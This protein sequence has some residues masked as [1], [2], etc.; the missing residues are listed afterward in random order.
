MNKQE[1]IKQFLNLLREDKDLQR[2]WEDNI[3]MVFK[4]I[5][6]YEF[7]KGTSIHDIANRSASA[8]LSLLLKKPCDMYEVAEK[9]YYYKNPNTKMDIPSSVYETVNKWYYEWQETN[10]EDFYEWCLKNKEQ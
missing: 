9:L 4:D 10:D 7:D 6:S 1:I 2:V 5:Y 8:F 3:A